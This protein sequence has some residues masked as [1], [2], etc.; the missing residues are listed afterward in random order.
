[1]PRS[2]AMGTYLK[3]ILIV[4]ALGFAVGFLPNR[5]RR[6]GANLFLGVKKTT[7]DEETIT[8]RDITE[9]AVLRAVAMMLTD[10]PYPNYPKSSENVQQ[11]LGSADFDMSKLIN[12][13]YKT[14]SSA[15]RK[16]RKKRFSERVEDIH[17]YNGK[18]DSKK[19]ELRVAHA[20]F[21]SEQFRDGQDRLVRFRRTVSLEI[22]EGRYHTARTFTG[23]MLHTLQDFYSHTNWVENWANEE[24]SLRP[25]DV[26]GEMD[27][28]IENVVSATEATCSD[29]TAS[30]PISAI[31]ENKYIM[32]NLG[33]AIKSRQCFRC[34]DNINS[35]LIEQKLLTSGYYTGVEDKQGNKISKPRGKCSHG[36]IFDGTSGS[37]ATGGINKD[38]LHPKLSSHYYLHT[39]A[40]RVAEQHSLQMLL[41]I[42]NDVN[43]DGLFARFV[44]IEVQQSV[45]VAI[46]IDPTQISNTFISEVQQL[47]N[48][49]GINIQQDT[50]N[51]LIRYILVSLSDKGECVTTN[52]QDTN[53]LLVAIGNLQPQTFNNGEVPILTA[54]KCAAE[55]SQRDSPIFVFTDSPISDEVLLGRIQAILET[56]NLQVQII[57]DVSSQSLSKRSLHYREFHDGKQLKKRQT[58]NDIYQELTTFSEGQIIEISPNDISELGSFMTYFV[59]Q[60]SSSNKLISA[61]GFSTLNSPYTRVFLVDSYTFEILIFVTGQNINVSTF[62]PQGGNA[63][64]L[65]QSSISLDSSSAYIANI[66]IAESDVALYGEWRLTIQAEELFNVDVVGNSRLNILTEIFTTSPNSDEEINDV[67]P[68]TGNFMYAIFTIIGSAAPV[69]INYITLV[70]FDGVIYL[71]N[72][73]PDANLTELENNTFIQSFRCPN[74]EFQMIVRGI[75]DN[76]FNFSFLSDVFVDPVTI[77]LAFGDDDAGYALLGPESETVISASLLNMNHEDTFRL[78]IDMDV[79]PEE[80]SFITYTITPEMI[81]IPFNSTSEINVRI[82]LAPNTPVGF[83]VTLTLVAQSVNF[84]DVNDFITF[85]ITLAEQIKLESDSSASIVKLDVIMAMVVM[86]M[87]MILT[88]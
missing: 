47:V 25:Y 84:I 74:R 14:E 35:Q 19:G 87:M 16:R 69:T 78:T 67:K 60:G 83:S 66:S 72:F 71:E 63:N 6:F 20:H 46:V 9:K 80:A 88:M 44:G 81:S 13:Y 62:T 58:D 56:K 64:D 23:R 55:A 24:N 15:S 77:S 36:G 28:E 82:S 38:S 26:L 5:L 2:N 86:V 52:T 40:A 18:V 21:D 4:S 48:N 59:T 75:D 17:K 27:M 3:V 53:T 45:S 8:H 29:C 57:C 33:Q 41:K 54:V 50:E 42:R 37:S 1:M 51:L 31:T 85:D 22:R 73:E 76:G 30:G 39:M 79:E 68:L 12:A 61:Y 32:L 11:L 49:V 65:L 70:D 43:N 7:S 34:M 10:N